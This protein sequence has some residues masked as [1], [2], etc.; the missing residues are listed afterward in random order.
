MINPWHQTVAALAFAAVLVQGAALPAAPGETSPLPDG[1]YSD[2]KSHLHGR[3]QSLP[4]VVYRGTGSPPV[5]VKKRGGF[6]PRP[7]DAE[8][9]TNQTFGLQNHNLGLG[10]TLYSSTTRD[11]AV[12][13]RF[14][15]GTE[16]SSW[17]YRIHATPNMIDLNDSGF[18]VFYGGDEA[19]FAA[20]GGI[21]YDQIEAWVQVSYTGLINS[22]MHRSDVDKLFDGKEIDSKILALN[23][24]TNPDYNHK[25][26]SLSASPG[27]P[28][29]AGDEDNVAKFG[30]KS[31]EEHAIE[32]MKKNGKPVGWDGKFPLSLL[33]TDALPEPERE[34]K[35]S[36]NSDD[37]FGLS[38]AKCRTQLRSASSKNMGRSQT[39]IGA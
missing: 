38:K 18:D 30:Q 36:A 33:Q 3:Q 27:Q 12:G 15:L 24:T 34:T 31:L 6:I 9:I 17:V 20:L 32:F 39:S 10:R 8:P 1:D 16:N 21:R 25:Y 29:L 2:P 14:A 11:L 23:F 7:R 13:V 37:D 4:T 22:G 5:S 35:L 19:E 26:D 28:Q